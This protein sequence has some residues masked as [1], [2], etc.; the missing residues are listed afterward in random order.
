MHVITYCAFI[1]CKNYFKDTFLR[2]QN[3]SDPAFFPLFFFAPGYLDGL[4]KGCHPYLYYLPKYL[5]RFIAI[6]INSTWTSLIKV[7]VSSDVFLHLQHPLTKHL[8]LILDLLLDECC[9]RK[10]SIWKLFPLLSAGTCMPY[11]YR[12]YSKGPYDF[13]CRDW[14]SVLVW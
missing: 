8:A 12:K 14:S 1:Q 6:F 13:Y 2:L 10:K 9:H 11:L 5:K 3:Q 4:N 7:M